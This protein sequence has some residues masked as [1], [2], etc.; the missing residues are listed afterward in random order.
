[1]PKGHCILSIQQLVR[2]GY[3]ME[4]IVWVEEVNGQLSVPMTTKRKYTPKKKEFVGWAS[5]QLIEFLESIGRDTSNKFSQDDV[6][7]IISDYVNRCKLID[8]T[9]K[10]RILCDERLHSLF[11]RKTVSRIK[12]YDL[13]E[14]HFPE[15]QE[16]D[17]FFSSE[18]DEDVTFMTAGKQQKQKL[19]GSDKK[20]YQKKNVD[21]MSNNLF[22][23]AAIVPENMKLVYLRRSMVQDLLK[24][25][26][27]FPSKVVGSF[28]R[29]KS[30]PNDYF[31]KNSHQLMQVTGI[32]KG[33]G[34][35]DVSTDT[36]LQVSDSIKDISICMLSD[37]NFSE[38]ECDQLRQRV[39]DGFLKRPTFVEFEQ[40]AHVLHEDLTKHWLVRELAV[41]QNLIDRAN[42]KGWRRELFEY[43]ERRQLLQMPSEQSRLLLELPKVIQDE[44]EPET[45][46]A[47]S[48]KT[49]NQSIDASP[50]PIIPGNSKFPSRSA[51]AIVSS[52]VIIRDS[53]MVQKENRVLI[54]KIASGKEAEVIQVAISISKQESK[55]GERVLYQSVGCV[56]GEQNEEQMEV[57]DEGKRQTHVRGEQKEEQTEVR[58]ESNRQTQPVTEEKNNLQVKEVEKQI[59]MAEVI[60]LSDDDKEAGSDGNQFLSGGNHVLHDHPESMIWYYVDP[61]GEKQ[62]PF[63]MSSLKRWS[64]CDYFPPDFTVWKR[65]QEKE[66]AVLLSTILRRMFPI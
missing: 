6:A 26:G 64:D 53:S 2:C 24:D 15:N 33:S 7:A 16:D 49:E 46:K 3:R 9:R 38:E 59:P 30:D 44:I 18:E 12:I 52:E 22:A 4:E 29:I 32:K 34:T 47:S 56:R 39:K 62:G 14:A 37:E 23:F 60:D 41:L 65:G 28:V 1:M 43:L 48:P 8:P 10:K 11:G 19:S 54:K 25:P 31:Q 45:T 35:G 66:E 13:L 57:R 36:L 51:K 63:S 50:H 58:D 40:K 55:S 61:Q 27:T 42:E 21:D 5:R 20:T 17:F